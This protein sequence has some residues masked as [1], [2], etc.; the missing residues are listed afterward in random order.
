MSSEETKFAGKFF[1]E[2]RVVMTRAFTLDEL[3]TLC[4]EQELV[5]DDIPGDVLGVKARGILDECRRTRR[6]ADL[7]DY[8]RRNRP[9]EQ[10]PEP[11]HGVKVAAAFAALG[12]MLEHDV[13][14]RDAVTRFK[15]SFEGA[16][17]RIEYVT[18]FKSLHDQLHNLQIR[19][20]DLLMSELKQVGEKG[21]QENILEY[22]ARFKTIVEKLKEIN[23]RLSI[24]TYDSRWI[25]KLAQ[26]QILM[27]I[28]ADPQGFNLV[29]IRKAIQ[30]TNNILS[31]HPTNING[32]LMGAVDSLNLQ[33][34]KDAMMN[35]S[36]QFARFNLDQEKVQ[37]FQT[38]I[39]S[40][41]SL[42]QRLIALSLEHNPW[43]DIDRILRRIYEQMEK[44]LSELETA[45]PD[46]QPRVGEILSN[47][48]EEWAVRLRMKDEE[49]AAALKENPKDV[50]K[51]TQCFDDYREQA[52]Q[53][54]F[55]VDTFLLNLCAELGEMGKRLTPLLEKM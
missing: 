11:T 30:D 35:V 4:F 41:E 22:V 36:K 42:N 17:V 9:S 38:G 16:N 2:M 23:S 19:C 37:E 31:V 14:L 8:C 15:H 6:I 54:F 55:N 49:L 28:A 53:R 50:A 45:W 32:R 3:K 20:Y 40:L 29:Q 25:T 44:D 39:S 1:E 34:L 43:Q 48:D 46:L 13:E 21:A 26:A 27:A 24:P 18:F 51:I 33:S 7:L 52:V 10:W 47:S 12:Q 5:Y